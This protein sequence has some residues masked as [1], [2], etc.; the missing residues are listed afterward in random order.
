[1]SLIESWFHDYIENSEAKERVGHHQSRKEYLQEVARPNRDL[2]TKP[3]DSENRESKESR[4]RERK[5]RDDSKKRESQSGARESM[6]RL[7]VFEL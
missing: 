2:A 6:H 5:N 7:E 1:M 4:A 3:I